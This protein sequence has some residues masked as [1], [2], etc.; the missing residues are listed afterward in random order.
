M[1]LDQRFK[2]VDERNSRLLSFLIFCTLVCLCELAV[3]SKCVKGIRADE[4]IILVIS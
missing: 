3:T 1:S 2:L 4:R